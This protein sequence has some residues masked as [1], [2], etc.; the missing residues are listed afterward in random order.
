MILH[1]M[2]LTVAFTASVSST[3]LITEGTWSGTN[4]L[5]A[6][7]TFDN[8]NGR[9]PRIDYFYFETQTGGNKLKFS[10]SQT[11]QPQC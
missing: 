1:K 11:A 10:T 4:A 8:S 3:T 6:S 7:G 9:R 2:S 5:F